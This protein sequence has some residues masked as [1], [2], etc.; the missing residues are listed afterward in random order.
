MGRR[1][2]F[3]NSRPPAADATQAWSSGRVGCGRALDEYHRTVVRPRTRLFLGTWAATVRTTRLSHPVVNELVVRNTVFKYVTLAK[4]LP[5]VLSGVPRQSIPLSRSPARWGRQG[6]PSHFVLRGF[7]H[8][9]KGLQSSLIRSNGK[10]IEPVAYDGSGHGG[11]AA[12]RPR[13]RGP[14]RTPRSERGYA[15]ESP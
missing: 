14:R 5:K 15:F 7:L 4:R 12:R 1:A 6:M 10:L 11:H 8:R 13:P 9:R 2:R 3:S